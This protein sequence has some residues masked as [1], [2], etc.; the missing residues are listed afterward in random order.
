MNAGEVGILIGRY[1]GDS[2]AGGNPWQ[3]LTAVLGELFYLGGQATFK[4]VF[5]RS[6][7]M[8][9]LYLLFLI[10]I[11]TFFFKREVKLRGDYTLNRETNKHWMNLLQLEDGAT[12]RTLARA[13]V[14]A[15]D[16]VMTRLFAHVQVKII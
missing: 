12:A 14:A 3:L 10:I 4:Y 1:P 9:K 2:Y 13:Q 16:A 15:G 11:V 7:K 6:L 5:V 8:S